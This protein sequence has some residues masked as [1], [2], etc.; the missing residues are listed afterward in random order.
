[1]ADTGSNQADQDFVVPGA[2]EFERFDCQ[3]GAVGAEYGGLDVMSPD[4]AEVFQL[5]TL[6]SHLQHDFAPGV[7]GLAQFMGFGGLI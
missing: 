7:A 4:H 5:H 3:P 2:F 1:M 6:M